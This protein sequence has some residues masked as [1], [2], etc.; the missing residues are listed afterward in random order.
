MLERQLQEK[1]ALL[2]KDGPSEA[3]Q[4]AGGQEYIGTAED[5]KLV[6]DI[7]KERIRQH[8]PGYGAPSDDQQQGQQ[9]GQGSQPVAPPKIS[10]PSYLDPEVQKKVQLLVNV[11]FQTG[12][13]TA[14][15]QV[16][17]THNSALIDAFHDILTDKLVEEL[18]NRRMI[19]DVK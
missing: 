12:L 8:M 7:V 15:K 18:K 13:Q 11:A 1:R 2:G 9:A 17:A 14:I 16:L 5:R 6:Y 10:Y 3:G 4:D 19:E